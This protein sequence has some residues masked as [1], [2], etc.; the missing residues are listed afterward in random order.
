MWLYALRLPQLCLGFFTVIFL[1][2]W[3]IAWTLNAV[4]GTL[5]DLYSLRDMYIWLTLQL[6]A[7]YAIN[8]IWNSP[9]GLPPGTEGKAQRYPAANRP[10]KFSAATAGRRRKPGQMPNAAA[11]VKKPLQF[12]HK[13]GRR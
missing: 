2:I 6:N 7:T 12:S 4:K 3:L 11:P 10:A 8:S 13:P 9:G 5:F 1:I